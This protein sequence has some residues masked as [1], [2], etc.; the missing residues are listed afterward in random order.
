MSKRRDLALARFTIIDGVLVMDK[1]GRE[2]IYDDSIYVKISAENKKKI[3]LQ[4][5]KSGSIKND[6]YANGDILHNAIKK[7]IDVFGDFTDAESHKEME[8]TLHVSDA[9]FVL[10]MSRKIGFV[11][12]LIDWYFKEMNLN[13]EVDNRETR[14]EENE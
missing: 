12:F 1:R 5:T 2:V 3:I 6:S 10:M 8:F 13:E 11:N 4:N 9:K 7:F 14:K